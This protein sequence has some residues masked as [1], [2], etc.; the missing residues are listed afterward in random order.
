[1]LKNLIDFD[2]SVLNVDNTLYNSTA[3]RPAPDA[4]GH[5]GDSVLNTESRCRNCSFRFG[6]TEEADSEKVIFM[7]MFL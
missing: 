5:S 3:R 4:G 7:T 2:N 6:L 1:V